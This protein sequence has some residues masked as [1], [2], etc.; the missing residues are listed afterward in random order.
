[1]NQQLTQTQLQIPAQQQSIPITFP[2][3]EN[4]QFKLVNQC[5]GTTISSLFAVVSLLTV[6]DEI[7]YALEPNKISSRL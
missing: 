2:N 3:A 7:Y 5:C 4:D 6:I 1:M